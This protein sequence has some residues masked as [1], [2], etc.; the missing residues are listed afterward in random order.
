MPVRWVLVVAIALIAAGCGGSDGSPG[1]GVLG[2]SS[3]PSGRPD[4]TIRPRPT[5]L[6]SVDANAL[7]VKVTARTKSVRRPGSASVAVKTAANA[8]CG[9]TV[10][11][12]TGP[13]TAGGLEPK[14]A[15][16]NGAVTWK[17]KVT[18]ATKKGTWPIAVVC[19]L[20]PRSGDASTS[21]T[22]K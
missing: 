20:G 17:W 12:A 4:P 13:S 8:S 6:A 22:V 10:T 16:S 21:V 1:I 18:S 14:T 15:G 19:S 5:P 2:A 11:Y 3:S 9:I 7:P